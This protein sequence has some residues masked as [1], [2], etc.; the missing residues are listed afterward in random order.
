MLTPQIGI[1]PDGLTGADQRAVMA[2]IQSVAAALQIQV[3][4]H[5]GP[6]WNVAATI[7]PFSALSAVPAGFWP[8]IVRESID[9]PNDAGYHLDENNQPYALI[10]YAADWTLTA[11]HELLEMLAD[12]F[13]SRLVAGPSADPNKPDDQVR[14]LVEVCDPVES[15]DYAYT[16]NGVV[17]SDFF[18]PDYHNPTGSAKAR[19]DY[20]GHLNAPRQ[21]LD[22][23][24]LSW[25]DL[26]D[27]LIY[28][29]AVDNGQSKIKQ[30]GSGTFSSSGNRAIREFVNAHT[31]A[32]KEFFVASRGAPAIAVK[33]LDGVRRAAAARAA[34]LS[35][36]LPPIEK[37]S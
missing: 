27:G 18:T 21:V 31:P 8:M 32:P 7:S 22:G 37:A 23:G 19:Y 14:Y 13:G 30:V 5:F 2:E 10:Q 25:E 24:Y 33:R 29:L 16:V 1:V 6:L 36:Q 20:M 17:V 15:S 9:D 34:M 26:T 12:P 11:S 28:Q 35:A 4:K 3:D